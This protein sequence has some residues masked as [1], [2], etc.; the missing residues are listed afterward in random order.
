MG[1]FV[2]RVIAFLI[3][4]FARQIIH[5]ALLDYE[6]RKKK[7][8]VYDFINVTLVESIAIMMGYFV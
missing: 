2:T 6:L 1:S 3:V 7:I 5:D 8:D 4:S